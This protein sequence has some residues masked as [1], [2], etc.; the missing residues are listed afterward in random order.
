MYGAESEE[1]Q[2]LKEELT[3]VTSEYDKM[4]G[5]VNANKNNIQNYTAQLERQRS[6]LLDLQGQLKQTNEEI[7]KQGNKFTEASQKFADYAGKL[8]KAG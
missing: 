1:A 5:K 6:T 8:E 4:Q 2:K 7:E 3:Q